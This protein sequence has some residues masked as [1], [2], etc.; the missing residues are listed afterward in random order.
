M[1]KVLPSQAVAAIDSM[2]EWAKNE[3]AGP[4][5]DQSHRPQLAALL[6]VVNG[7]PSELL[8]VGGQDYV[9]FIAGVADV[10]SSVSQME[11]GL[12]STVYGISGLGG[13][14]PI[15]LIRKALSL[16]PDE[17][18][19]AG[20]AT[21]AFIKDKTYR[22]E[23]RRD[24]SGASQALL[25]GEF[26]AATVLGG[27][28]VEA[29]LHWAITSHGVSLAQ[30]AGQQLHT[31]SLLPHRKGTTQIR[32]HGLTPKSRVSKTVGRGFESCRPNCRPNCR[33]G[34]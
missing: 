21:L 14:H 1:P 20:T 6:E 32:K 16:C 34:P 23:L 15:T 19:R 12:K 11:R 13:G 30:L 29:L 4:T 2:F 9:S 17:V 22:E 26:K 7:V 28:V 10:R 33:Q 27:S 3:G 5:L 24:I 18:A 31:K 25:N 8:T